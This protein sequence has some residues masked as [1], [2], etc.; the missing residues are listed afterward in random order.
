MFRGCT[1]TGDNANPVELMIEYSIAY[2]PRVTN[3]Y[4]FF[5]RPVVSGG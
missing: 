2:Q 5:I 1:P 4:V 3:E